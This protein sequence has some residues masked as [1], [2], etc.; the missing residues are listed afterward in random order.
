MASAFD[1]EYTATEGPQ[2]PP[3]TDTKTTN[4]YVGSSPQICLFIVIILGV[5]CCICA[6]I[7]VP[8]GKIR[9][10]ANSATTIG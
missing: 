5:C 1:Y 3:F 8:G 7:S 9:A 2:I 4:C 10:A 6:M